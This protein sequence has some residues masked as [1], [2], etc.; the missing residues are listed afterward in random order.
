MFSLV[1]ICAAYI[2]IT[3]HC[4]CV[5]GLRGSL[6][7]ARAKP[8]VCALQILILLDTTGLELI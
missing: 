7:T 8:A 3:A 4:A 5:K 1:Y 6:Q 2:Q